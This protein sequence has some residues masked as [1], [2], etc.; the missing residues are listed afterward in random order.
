MVL[1]L[2]VLGPDKLQ[3]YRH[4]WMQTSTLL[5]ALDWPT[6]TDRAYLKCTSRQRCKS[7]ST[8]MGARQFVN[9]SSR[10]KAAM[11][12]ACSAHPSQLQCQHRAHSTPGDACH[13]APGS[14]CVCVCVCAVTVAQHAQP[15]PTCKSPAVPAPAV[16]SAP[17]LGS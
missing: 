2:A 17:W 13:P 1:M 11:A 6:R 10:R 14:M 7:A 15:S 8:A 9:S 5:Q 4:A 16:A 3:C 12:P